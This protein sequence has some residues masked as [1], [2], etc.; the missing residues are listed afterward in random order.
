MH[1]S[2]EP[3]ADAISFLL[4]G[5]KSDQYFEGNHLYIHKSSSEPYRL[6]KLYLTSHDTLFQARPKLW[7]GADGTIPTCAWFI[8]CLCIFFQ[9][10]V[11]GQSMRAGEAT[12]LAKAG[13]SYK[14]LEGGPQTPSTATF[15]KILSFLKLCLLA[16]RPVF[17]FL[18]KF[19]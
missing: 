10:S 6:F 9:T 16:V 15:E 4:P 2:V 13:T 11:T 19:S 7:L 12:A 18:L 14:Q 17:L 5:H 8:H 1:H 3:L